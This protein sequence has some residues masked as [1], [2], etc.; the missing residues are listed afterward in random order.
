MRKFVI[1]TDDKSWKTPRGRNIY[2]AFG[3]NS[4]G[5]SAEHPTLFAGSS[6]KAC[7][8]VDAAIAVVW[9]PDLEENVY[10]EKACLLSIRKAMAAFLA[11]A[12]GCGLAIHPR[13]NKPSI[14]EEQTRIVSEVLDGSP[15]IKKIYHHE[16]S[17]PYSLYRAAIE[18][19]GT[20][21]FEENLRSLAI[22]F[23]P[24][25]VPAHEILLEGLP[26]Y[27]LGT[28]PASELPGTNE[29]WRRLGDA[30]Q[31]PLA[32]EDVRQTI[33][34]SMRELGTPSAYLSLCKAMI[35]LINKHG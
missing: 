29:Q 11:G 12:D 33:R 15:I 7:P 6:G 5:F 24:P 18:A 13:A 32:V 14:Q 19:A 10:S 34:V 21:V 27:L 17:R 25:E 23:Q 3:E 35:T 26:D 28:S 4:A 8:P 20:T 30:L 22:W 9:E 31:P 1:F 2:S 16:E